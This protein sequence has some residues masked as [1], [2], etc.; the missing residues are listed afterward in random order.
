MR[1]L[2]E[3]QLEDRIDGQA[4]RYIRER[5]SDVADDWFISAGFSVGF[6]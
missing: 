4:V 6:P 3:T 2:F 5:V 1:S